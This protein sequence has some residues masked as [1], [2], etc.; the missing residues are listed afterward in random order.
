[1]V[2]AINNFAVQNHASGLIRDLRCCGIINIA[3]LGI[4]P[5]ESKHISS[6]G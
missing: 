1:M 3:P 4:H 5:A 6:T 2:T